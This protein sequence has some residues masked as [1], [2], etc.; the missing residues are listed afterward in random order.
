MRNNKKYFFSFVEYLAIYFFDSNKTMENKMETGG[1]TPEKE[2]ENKLKAEKLHSVI[3]QSLAD[4]SE[5]F[6]EDIPISKEEIIE[7]IPDIYKDYQID[8]TIPSD[9]IID[10]LYP[11]FLEDWERER[12]D[13]AGFERD[14]D[15]PNPSDWSTDIKIEDAYPDFETWRKTKDKKEPTQESG[16]EITEQ[17]MSLHDFLDLLKNKIIDEL[18]KIDNLGLTDEQ[19]RDLGIKKAFMGLSGISI[20]RGLDLGGTPYENPEIKID[21]DYFSKDRNGLQKLEEFLNSEL[22]FTHFDDSFWDRAES[23]ESELYEKIKEI[24]KQTGFRP[25]DL[26]N[27]KENWFK[28]K[29]HS[30][31]KEKERDE[32]VKN[33]VGPYEAKKRRDEQDKKRYAKNKEEL[34]KELENRKEK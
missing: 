7:L 4:A 31:R 20:R 18:A 19:K 33:Y 21:E 1:T 16:K 22:K 3:T 32:R 2:Q 13:R 25:I 9:D 11:L 34:I 5:Y 28:I 26:P 29:E 17:T 23:L 12:K 27:I 8:E 10:K 14:E 6:L 24:Y 15:W 30:E